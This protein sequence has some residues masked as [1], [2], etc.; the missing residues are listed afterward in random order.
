[1]PSN[2]DF[3]RPTFPDLYAH[4]AQAEGLIYV[5]PRACCF[6]TRFAL[7]QTV[8]WL[9]ENNPNLR[10]PFE[11]SLGAMIH[12]PSFQRSLKPGLFP[13]IRLIQ[14]QGNKAVHQSREVQEDD[15]LRLVQEL[16]HVLY[17]L[18]RTYR[19][20][21]QALP[22]LV[23]DRSQVTRPIQPEEQALTQQQLQVLAEQLTESDALRRIAVERRQQTE[24]E[25]TAA[26]A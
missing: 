16:F 9:Y 4:A 5:N 13:K 22:N 8:L 3:L 19:R 15:A 21:G 24:A 7:E 10:L 17:W 23:F 18:C 26:Q 2:F 1:M 14:K 11:N 6:Y 20:Q 12:E 25:L